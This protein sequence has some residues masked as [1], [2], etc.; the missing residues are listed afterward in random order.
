MKKYHETVR[1]QKM[2]MLKKSSYIA[3]ETLDPEN[4]KYYITFD[5]V[6][7]VFPEITRYRLNKELEAGNLPWT[8]YDT[9]LMHPKPIELIVK[10]LRHDI[11]KKGTVR[12]AKR[13]KPVRA[14]NLPVSFEVFNLAKQ[15]RQKLDLTSDDD[16]LFLAFEALKMSNVKDKLQFLDEVLER[17]ENQI[18]KLSIANGKLKR[19][20]HLLRKLEGVRLKLKKNNLIK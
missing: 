14:Y 9:I 16:L 13:S 10:V 11:A 5:R 20:T 8:Y 15:I 17:N 19:R 18:G 4:V 3:I 1:F 6:L 12:G 7:E 2:P